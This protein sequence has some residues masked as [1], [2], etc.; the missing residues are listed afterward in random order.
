MALENYAWPLQH[1]EIIQTIKWKFEIMVDASALPVANLKKNEKAGDWYWQ[2]ACYKW[3]ISDSEIAVAHN[4]VSLDSCWFALS[5]HN[6]VVYEV[7]RTKVWYKFYF[8]NWIPCYI[9]KN[10]Q[11]WVILNT[12]FS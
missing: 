10:W 4:L 6:D 12:L 1:C 7:D 9:Y 3:S 2:S 11:F 5:K 8:I